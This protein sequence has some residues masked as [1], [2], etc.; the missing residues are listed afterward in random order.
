MNIP[1]LRP[2]SFWVGEKGSLPC[3][4]VGCD[5][6]DATLNLLGHNA[7]CRYADC[8]FF[9]WL[10]WGNHDTLSITTFGIMPHDALGRTPG[11]VLSS[12]LCVPLPWCTAP[13]VY[14]S[15]ILLLPQFTAPS[16]YCS[17]SVRLPQ[18]TA[19]SVY[20]YLSVL[21][22]QCTAPLVHHSFGALLPWCATP[23]VHYS[24]GALLP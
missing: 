5:G 14:C 10:C 11:K 7:E 19:P 15:L 3:L 2:C 6:T 24:L 13:S 22:P 4:W 16:V 1:K 18:C 9:L 23:L 17:L 8:H 12:S 20:C 21:L